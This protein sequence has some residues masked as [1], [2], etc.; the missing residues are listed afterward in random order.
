MVGGTLIVGT[1]MDW[2][3]T[4]SIPLLSSTVAVRAAVN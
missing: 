4:T 3:P 1:G 2:G